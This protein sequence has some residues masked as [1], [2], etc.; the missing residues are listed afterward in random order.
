MMSIRR[1]SKGYVPYHVRWEQEHPKQ[2]N[3]EPN[4]EDVKAILVGYVL[5]AL[6][7]II[8]TLVII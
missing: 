8:T 2:P 5:I 7:A 4:K 3:M 1:Y 6:C